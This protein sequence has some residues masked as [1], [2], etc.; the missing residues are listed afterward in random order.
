MFHISWHLCK[1]AC[2]RCSL[3]SWLTHWRVTC[4]QSS[5]AAAYCGSIF[6][7]C[8]SIFSVTAVSL[9]VLEAWSAHPRLLLHKRPFFTMFLRVA[10]WILSCP[11]KIRAARYAVPFVKLNF[12]VTLA[13]FVATILRW[14][15]F[16]KGRSV[17]RYSVVFKLCTSLLAV[18]WKVWR[19]VCTP[20]SKNCSK[21]LE[22]LRVSPPIKLTRTTASSPSM[23][24]LHACHLRATASW[25]TSSGW[26]SAMSELHSLPIVNSCCPKI[27]G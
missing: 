14:P 5:A 26:T 8:G 10:R 18:L 23:H 17:S 11:R 25:P 15:R 24:A 1:D 2:L 27:S 6:S 13:C 22:R 7:Y 20:C 9:T 3:F 16:L 21:T 4:F 12:D 19:R